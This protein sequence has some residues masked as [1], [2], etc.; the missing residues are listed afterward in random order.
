ML[1]KPEELKQI[2]QNQKTGSWERMPR[3]ESRKVNKPPRNQKIKKSKK[4]PGTECPDPVTIS[5][6]A[7]ILSPFVSSPGREG[8]FNHVNFPMRSLNEVD[9]APSVHW[10]DLLTQHTMT[11]PFEELER[12]YKQAIT[13]NDLQRQSC[14][15]FRHE[16]G[17]GGEGGAEWQV[18]HLQALHLPAEV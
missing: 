8:I 14:A 16:V 9:C 7:L 2:K 13:H 3:S 17:I 1:K 6:K 5:L 11:V 18:Y 4:S 10:V 15:S 12:A